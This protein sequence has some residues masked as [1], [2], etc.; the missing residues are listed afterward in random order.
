MDMT[1]IGIGRDDRS[2]DGDRR[3]PRPRSG[4]RGWHGERTA[5][6]LL[7]RLDW[8]GDLVPDR[9]PEER[10]R[11]GE[12]HRRRPEH[13][14]GPEERDRRLEHHRGHEH[15]RLEHHRGLERHHRLHGGDIGEHRRAHRHERHERWRH[16]GSGGEVEMP[17]TV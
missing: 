15:P 2:A 17:P 6:I 13:H 10:G 4:F 5:R 11:G 3:V 7:R 1:E 16:A 14:H 8:Q 9:G 12:V